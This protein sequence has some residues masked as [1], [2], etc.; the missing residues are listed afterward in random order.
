MMLKLDF[1][2]FVT[3][4]GEINH[5]LNPISLYRKHMAGGVHGNMWPPR[6]DLLL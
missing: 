6:N 5:P 3:S 1:E 4:K 2:D